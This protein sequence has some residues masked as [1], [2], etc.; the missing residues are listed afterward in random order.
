MFVFRDVTEQQKTE[1]ELLKIKKIESIGVLAGG[2]AHDFNNI[3]VAILGNINL[4]LMDQNLKDETRNFLKEAEKASVRAKDLTQQLLT[5]SKGGEPIKKATSLAK[6]VTDSANFVL[7]GL[8]VTCQYDIPGDLWLVEI[9]KGQISQVVQ[10]IV[11]NAG[12]SMP[13]GGVI[14]I[15][16]SNVHSTSD[17]NIRGLGSG[18]FVKMAF[19]DHGTGIPDDAIERIFDPYFSTKKGGSG[20]G[21]AITHSIINKHGGHISVESVPGSSTTFNVYLPV[22]AEHIS[23]THEHELEQTLSQSSSNTKI[24]V[25]DDDEMVRAVVKAMLQQLGHEVLLAQDGTE[26]IQ[27]YKKSMNS[28]KLTDIVIMDLTIPGGMGGKEAV[29]E[30]LALN[31][32]AKVIVSSGYSNDPIMANFKEHGFCDA[33]IKPY[34]VEEL[35]RV[36]HNVLG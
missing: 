16:C 7:S 9:D 34:Q 32:Q 12:Q 3:L 21:L 11:I 8:P 5:F 13:D 35:S 26:A 31:P 14:E 1:K 36:I 20:L 17:P 6:I 4:S 22:S 24:I 30:I 29:Q 25:M 23:D 18:K 15:M 10:N 2:I 27:L 19:Q 33:I 28:E